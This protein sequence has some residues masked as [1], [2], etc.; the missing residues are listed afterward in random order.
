[1]RICVKVGGALVKRGLDHLAE[2]LANLA[3][4]HEFVVVH[5][6]GP[7]ID[8]LCDLTGV[9]RKYLQSPSGFRSRHTDPPTLRVAVLA[10]AGE[11]NKT[12]VKKLAAAGLNPVGF[13]GVDGRTLLAKRKEKVITVTPEGRRFVVRDDYS[14]KVTEADGTL[15]RLLLG[16]GFT[17]VVGSLATTERGE[18]VNVDGDRA[19]S[20]LARATD[21][22]L[23][24]SLTDVEGVFEDVEKRTVIPRL[25]RQAAERLVES[26]K[27]GMKKKV[28]A[29]LEALSLGVPRVVIG[30]GTT[31]G[32]LGKLLAGKAGT[33]VT[34]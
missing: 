11:T 34:Q 25:S 4:E 23:L 14:G 32:P 19:A 7:Q 28:F 1:M 3:A 9:E 13:T 8:E 2:D 18:L 24:A 33:V 15:C 22:D 12:I 27:G 5:G 20:H 21:C 30:S 29:A 10:L 6:G 26:L 31:P 16:A 17:P